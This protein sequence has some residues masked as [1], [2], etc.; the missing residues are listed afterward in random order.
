MDNT[1]IA[2]GTTI[3]GRIEGARDIVID[4]EIDG[5][6]YAQAVRIGPDGKISGKIR[7]HSLQVSGSMDGDVR[8]RGRLQIEASGSVTGRIVYG[9]LSIA[10]GGNLNAHVKN[11]PPFISGDLIITVK[12]GSSVVIDE[13]SLSA[14]DA[15]DDASD[16]TF[17][18]ETIEGVLIRREGKPVDDFTLDDIRRGVLSLE[19]DGKTKNPRF[20]VI[21]TDGISSTEKHIIQIKFS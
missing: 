21:V 5:D 11:L 18:I 13:S 12:Q 16:V 19:H 2:A 4:G 10:E 15:D 6:L 3:V 14:I 17:R 7:S 20:E 8:A 1:R 9:S